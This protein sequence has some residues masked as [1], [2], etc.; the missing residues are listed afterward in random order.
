MST[1]AQIEFYDDAPGE[2]GNPAARIYQHS[3]GYPE[4]AE[5]TP[6][7][8]LKALEKIL[9]KPAGMYGTR[10]TDPEWAAAEYINQYR[11]PGSGGIY[12]TQNIHGDIEYLYRVICKPKKWEI[13]VFQS[14][15]DEKWDIKGFKELH[16]RGKKWLPAGTVTP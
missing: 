6:L 9:A 13:R 15:H 1:R 3:D 8:R 12:V 2:F 11:E 16:K 10:L 14:E 7:G 5:Y 4:N